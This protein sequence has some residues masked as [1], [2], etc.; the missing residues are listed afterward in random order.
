LVLSLVPGT[1]HPWRRAGVLHH[2]KARTRDVGAR[3]KSRGQKGLSPRRRLSDGEVS[4][5]TVSRRAMAV[6]VGH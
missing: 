4:A 3:V 1:S 2:Q 6:R 5:R